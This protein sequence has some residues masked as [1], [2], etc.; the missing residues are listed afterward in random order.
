MRW[1]SRD[2]GVRQWGV[3]G[4]GVGG[5]RGGGVGVWDSWSGPSSPPPGR[6]CRPLKPLGG[7]LRGLTTEERRRV[8][9]RRRPYLSFPRL[10]GFPVFPSSR[11]AHVTQE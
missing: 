6:P 11:N 2:G 5:S 8:S 4:R 3:D 1:G 10:G 7:A 9:L